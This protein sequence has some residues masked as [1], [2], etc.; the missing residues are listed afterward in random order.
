M[1]KPRFGGFC[2]KGLFDGSATISTNAAGGGQSHKLAAGQV[3]LDQH[4]GQ[5]HGDG[6]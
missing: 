6:G 4:P 2:I 5:Q 1:K 3:F